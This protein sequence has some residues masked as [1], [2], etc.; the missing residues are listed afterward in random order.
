MAFEASQAGFTDECDSGTIRAGIARFKS[1]SPEGKLAVIGIEVIADG[2]V[3][4]ESSIVDG[5]SA[6]ENIDKP[7]DLEIT[8]T[9]SIVLGTWV[10]TESSSLH[11]FDDS[12]AM[13]LP[14]DEEGDQQGDDDHDD[15]TDNDHQRVDAVR[16]NPH[17]AL[18]IIMRVS[19]GKISCTN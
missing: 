4:V 13:R 5:R 15:E 17:H 14:E 18:S 1:E 19:A 8:I 10:S 7:D 11:L 12:N 3:I 6:E 9:V 16:A 2:V